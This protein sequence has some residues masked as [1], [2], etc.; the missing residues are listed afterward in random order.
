MGVAAVA[1]DRKS[2]RG[3]RA[4]TSRRRFEGATRGRVGLGTVSLLLVFGACNGGRE[5]GSGTTGGG[6]TPSGGAGLGQGGSGGA[7]LSC[8]GGVVSGNGVMIDCPMPP[9]PRW[10]QVTCLVSRT[11]CSGWV[12]DDSTGLD[13]VDVNC[14]A[15]NLVPNGPFRA[16]ICFQSTF[17]TFEELQADAQIACD[18]YCAG[19]WQG[20]Y[21]LGALAKNVDGGTVTCSS[22][23]QNDTI[24]QE[25]NGQCSKTTPAPGGS[26]GASTLAN[27]VLYGR[28][29]DG[30]Q[31][32][33]DG[34][35]YCTSM[36]PVA[37]GQ[38]M[39]GCFD[40][41]TTTAELFCR[42]SFQFSTLPAGAADKSD[43]FPYWLVA[44][45]IQED[46][47]ADCQAQVNNL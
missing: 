13:G 4:A 22:I 34:T 12:E 29:C 38:T 43:Q 6:G 41:T 42:N 32:A 37:G 21:P 1:Q 39:T 8:D 36:R 20:L 7:S 23:A 5:L 18:Q 31:T 14:P 16:T 45:V 25:V 27:C 40:S 3:R 46:T 15:A 30:Q 2:G 44:G 9:R 24:D 11:E 28:T 33:S 17:R 35:R 10:E 26:S 19:G 47:V